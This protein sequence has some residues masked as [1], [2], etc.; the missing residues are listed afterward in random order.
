MEIRKLLLRLNQ[1]KQITILVS[2]HILTELQLVAKRFV[3]IKDGIIVEDIS[4]EALD[5]K[6]KKQ[7]LLKVDNP[8][9]TAQLLEDRKSTRLNSSHVANAYAVF[10][11][12]K[13]KQ[14]RGR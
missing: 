8:A 7:I 13:N 2:S 9:K 10:C 6:S 12:K 4:K 14:I 1:E 3:F 5:E 11:F